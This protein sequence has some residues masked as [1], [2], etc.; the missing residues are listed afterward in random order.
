MA[1]SQCSAFKPV[2]NNQ[3]ELTNKAAHTNNSLLSIST[4]KFKIKEENKEIPIVNKSECLTNNSEPTS[5]FDYLSSSS[6]SSSTSSS[7][8]SLSTHT[9]ANQI[10]HLLNS[11]TSITC[12]TP[13]TPTNPFYIDK[14]F[15]FQNM[16]LFSNNGSTT[17]TSTTT[18]NPGGSSAP[19]VDPTTTPTIPNPH[20]LSSLTNPQSLLAPF[21]SHLQNSLDENNGIFSRAAPPNPN[22]LNFNHDLHSIMQQNLIQNYYNLYNLNNQHNLRKKKQ[23]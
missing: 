5:A 23:L 10:Q 15:N 14:I 18:A 7:T 8:C 21:F 20:I 17:A 2:N 1:Q 9:K 3:A 22:L 6:S 12:N 16:F 11:A 4:Q 19:P 13:N